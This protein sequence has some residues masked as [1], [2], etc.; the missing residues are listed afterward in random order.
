MDKIPVSPEQYETLRQFYVQ[1]L[2]SAYKRH[3]CNL[4]LPP[5][6]FQREFKI[7]CDLEELCNAVYAGDI[8]IVQN[9][10]DKKLDLSGK[11]EVRDIDGRHVYYGKHFFFSYGRDPR[12]DCFGTPPMYLWEASG[13]YEQADDFDYYYHH[14]Y[15]YSMW[16]AYAGASL[17]KVA[18]LR[19]NFTICQLLLASGGT[20]DLEAS[21]K[22]DLERQIQQIQVNFITT[23][24]SSS[25]LILPLTICV[26][27]YFHSGPVLYPAVLPVNQNHLCSC[28]R[29][30][31][32][33]QHAEHRKLSRLHTHLRHQKFT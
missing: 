21:Q 11:V 33:N 15:L 1:R 28:L 8:E 16:Q 7:N 31:C 2:Y 24:R 14:Q 32:P 9:S 29:W 30:S 3:N 20:N 6:S 17:A 27:E 23:I 13:L 10:I 18:F 4:P 25:A 12:T 26:F 22:S 5:F 19:N